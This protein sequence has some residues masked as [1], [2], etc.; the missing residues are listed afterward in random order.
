[1]TRHTTFHRFVLKCLP[2]IVAAACLL[3]ESAGAQQTIFNVPSADVTPI[4]RLFLQQESQFRPWKPDRFMSNTSY[5]AWGVGHNT[6]LDL[7]LFNVS[8]PKSDNITLGVGFKSAIPLLKKRWPDRE[9]KLTVG[10]VLPVS[11][12]GKGVGNW[13]YAHASCRLPRVNTRLTAGITAGTRQVFG[14]NTVAAIAGI[15]HPLTPRVSLLADWYSG[16]HGLGL[17]ITGVSVA[18]P[19]DTALYAGYQI[20]NNRRSGRSGFVVELA[21]YLF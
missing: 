18:L 1:M 10:S 16:T 14:R 19:K 4:G 13:S 5:A 7:T 20:P 3:T 6:E 17:L 2:L 12:Q 9:I 21:K 11:L 8:V 15:E